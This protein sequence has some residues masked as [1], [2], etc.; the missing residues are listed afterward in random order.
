MARGPAVFAGYWNNP[1]ANAKAFAGGW[2]HTGDLG[3]MD[4]EGFLFV[5]G[6]RERDA[7]VYGQRLNLDEIEGM[8]RPRGPAAAISLLERILVFC[9]W[10]DD[11][12]LKAYHREFARTLNMHQGA[13]EFRRVPKIP[14]GLNGKVDYGALRSMA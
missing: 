7:K 5:T 11:I 14:V 2:F 9:E 12:S 8:V 3:V 4:E 10:G 6:R 1:D 13:L